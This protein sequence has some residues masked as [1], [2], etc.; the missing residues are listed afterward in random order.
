MEILIIIAVL[1]VLLW[2]FFLRDPAAKP[3]ESA[4]YK[5]ETP[6]APAPE[7]KVVV[8]EESPVLAVVEAPA[9]NDQIT[10]AVT[11]AEAPAKK[12]RKPR[13]PKAEKPAVKVAVKKAAAPKKAAAMKAPKAKTKSKKV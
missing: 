5:V 12:P 11:Q 4:P 9:V 10:D 2:F 3:V 13:A 6:P 8:V 1:A 7:V